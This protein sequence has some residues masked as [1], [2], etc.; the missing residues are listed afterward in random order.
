MISII[1]K[2]F[3]STI[4]DVFIL[5][6]IVFLTASIFMWIALPMVLFSIRNEIKKLNQ[7]IQDY[8]SKNK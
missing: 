3:T 5:V 6:L 4:Y 8:V 7:A 1:S 2:S